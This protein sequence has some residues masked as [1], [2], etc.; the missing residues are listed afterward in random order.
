MSAFDICPLVR[1]KECQKHVA[2]D[3]FVFHHRLCSSL[4]LPPNSFQPFHQTVPCVQKQQEPATMSSLNLDKMCG[5]IM[6]GVPCKRR[7]GCSQHSVG[8]KKLVQ[9]RS[10]PFQ[11]LIRME[12]KVS[13]NCVSLFV[14]SLSVIYTL[15]G[16]RVRLL[17]C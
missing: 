3:Y 2:R 5:V 10:K 15:Y 17:F 11:Q 1:C 7:L 13:F 9:G 16:S 12:K 8:L 6:N 14:Y 4:V